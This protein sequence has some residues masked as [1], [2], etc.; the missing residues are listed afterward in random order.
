LIV[1]QKILKQILF[2]NILVFLL[3]LFIGFR[4]LSLSIVGDAVHS[5]IDALNNIIALVFIKIAN[6]PADK[7]HPYGHSKFETLGALAIVGFLAIAA[8]ELIEKSVIRILHP[9]DCPHIDQL[10]IVLLICTLLVNVCVW[11][12]ERHAADKYSSQILKADASHTFADILITIS[13]LLSTFFIQAGYN[14]LDPL[15]GI[16]IAL[17]IARSAWKILQETIPILVDEAWLD[18][19]D[20]R[21]IASTMPQIVSIENFRSRKVHEKAFLEMSVSF[22]TDSLKEAHH[23]SHEFEQKIINKFGAAQITIHIEPK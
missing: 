8:F 12:Y 17:L 16:F 18:L 9:S 15:L 1:I 20:L 10:L 23:L 2:L 21:I 14:I 19:E 7:D 5:G 22:N 11:L 13:I 6:Q 4:A 3:K